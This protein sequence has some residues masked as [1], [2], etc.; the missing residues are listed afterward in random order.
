MTSGPVGAPVGGVSGPV[1]TQQGVAIVKV[2]ARQEATPTDFEAGKEKFRADTLNI[3]RQRF[4]QAYMEKART[5]MK[6]DI[7]NDA[8]KRAVGS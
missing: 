6:I 2:D 7:D 3:R 5:K 8:L 1:T 4:Y